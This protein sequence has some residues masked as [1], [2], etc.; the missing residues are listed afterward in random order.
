MKVK[1]LYDEV[2]ATF[3]EQTQLTVASEE[4]SELIKEI[5]K[6]QRGQGDMN[7]L[8]EELADVF[9]M[10]HQVMQF[11]G[12]ESLVNSFTCQKQSRLYKRL[13]G[14]DRVKIAKKPAEVEFDIDDEY[15]EIYAE[16]KKQL[17]AEALEKVSQLTLK[18]ALAVK[19]KLESRF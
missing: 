4:C 8:A 1:E 11:Y 9:I 12:L 19:Q 10:A 16:L 5:C 15:L 6:V 2:W 3:G 13:R 18:T 14:V 17:S 7:H